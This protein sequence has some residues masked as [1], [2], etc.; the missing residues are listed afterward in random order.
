MSK[1]TIWL[2]RSVSAAAILILLI[3]FFIDAG[4]TDNEIPVFS[5]ADAEITASILD[6]EEVLLEGVT[7]WDDQSG[8]LSDSVII[9]SIYAITKDGRATVTYAVSD[10]AGNTAKTERIVHYT[11]Y[12]SPRI[13]LS[14]PLVFEF[15]TYFDVLD[16]T[17]ANDVFEGDIS[18]RI[19][20]TMLSTG[21]SVSE[22]GHHE[23]QFRVTNSMGDTSQLVLPVEVYPAGSYN[24]QL[25]L[26]DYLI[27]LPA[28]STFEAA[29]YLAQIQIQDEILDLSGGIPDNIQISI[30]GK[31]NSA[32][33]GVYPVTYT[34]T[35]QRNGLVYTG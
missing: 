18:H 20:P 17:N 30:G 16:Y 11:D 3:Y 23:V 25:T 28:G 15:G 21:T 29:D 31:V 14:G 35:A 1:K 4:T 6:P 34:V 19:K 2:M 24:A 27:Y 5:I 33:P 8:D 7:A 10:H 13:T 26:T 32:E 12:T 22:E 9:E